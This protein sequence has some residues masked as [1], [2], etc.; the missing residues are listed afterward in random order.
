[1]GKS[2]PFVAMHAA[3]GGPVYTTVAVID[4]DLAQR[5]PAQPVPDDIISV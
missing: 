3:A 5:A 1:M 2:R 4:R